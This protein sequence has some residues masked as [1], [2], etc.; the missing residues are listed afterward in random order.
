MKQNP[1]KISELIFTKKLAKI[2]LLL[3]FIILLLLVNGCSSDPFLEINETPFTEDFE[4][5]P[6]VESTS[7][8]ESPTT[9]IVEE[10]PIDNS[11]SIE[12]ILTDY[13]LYV[14]FNYSSQIAQV[15]Q[16][17][18]FTNNSS[19][20]LTT[21]LLAC[22]P[23]RYPGSFILDKALINSD[24]E[25]QLVDKKFYFSL[26][27]PYSL[28]PGELIEIQIDYTLQI[29]PLPTPSGD[30][31][32]AIF[33]YSVVQTNFVDWYPFIPP[34][35]QNGNWILHDPWFYGEYLVYDLANFN[36]EIELLN[37]L[38]GTIIAASSLPFE[39][40][41]NSYIYKTQKSRN[42]AWSISP[43]FVEESKEINGISITTY[44]FPYHQQA[45]THILEETVKAIELFSEIF[46]PFPRDSLSIVEGDF[47]DGMEYDG[48]FF[49]GK[50]YFNLFDFTP[51]N[52]LTFIAV[53]ETAHQ[54]WYTSVAN[55]QALEPWLDEALC[56]YSELLYYEKYYPELVN[57]WWEYRV[58]FYQ[59]EGYINKPIYDY[60]GFIPYRDATYLRGAIFLQKLRNDIG[61]QVFFEILKE[62]AI[63]EE[64][65]IS[66][67]AIFLQIVKEFS[68]IDPLENYPEFLRN[69]QD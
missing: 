48:L 41:E 3:L 53:H 36:I 38:P 44:T 31:K 26:D 55:N 39:Q 35:D 19:E 47:F 37:T 40:K 8:I 54:W 51:K 22:D 15:S 16:T 4:S 18:N 28:E 66:S 50:G 67:E 2:S 46:S 65:K 9:P 62:Y 10:I 23:L 14:I 61:D 57:W 13:N 1:K 68:G 32:P 63:S 64:D 5:T 25:I 59:P 58:N 56:T 69:L 49:L 45:G 30:R 6:I 12:P 7:P 42:F 43:S 33:G 34:L 60:Q 24:Q 20:P 29:P 52:Y 27:L 21:I 17:I 11:E